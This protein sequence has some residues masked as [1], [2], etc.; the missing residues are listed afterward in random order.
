LTEV[1]IGVHSVPATALEYQK[2]IMGND[3][4]KA[5]VFLGPHKVAVEER[6]VPRIQDPTDIIVKVDKVFDVFTVH[7]SRN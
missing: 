5:V 7:I 4:M 2:S 1:L 6:P 3:T